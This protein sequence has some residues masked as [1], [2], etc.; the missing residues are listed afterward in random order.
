MQLYSQSFFLHHILCLIE[1]ALFLFTQ[2]LARSL[3]KR[4]WLNS[5][6]IR[7]FQHSHKLV[8]EYINAFYNSV[9][10]HSHGNFLSLNDFENLYKNSSLSM[11]S[12]VG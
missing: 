5:F 1:S 7:N 3:I 8:F 12:L 4:E 9:R 2:N 11:F 10:I 6:R